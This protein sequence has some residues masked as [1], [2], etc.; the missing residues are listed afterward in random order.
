[1][2]NQRMRRQTFNSNSS[3]LINTQP[4]KKIPRVIPNAPTTVEKNKLKPFTGIA[5][6]EM[7]QNTDDTAEPLESCNGLFE[8]D[9][10]SLDLLVQP[11]ET[12]DAQKSVLCKALTSLM[13]D[14]GTSDED[15]EEKGNE[16]LNKLSE[17]KN[18]KPDEPQISN[19]NKKDIPVGD[20]PKIVDNNISEDEGPEEVVILKT[21]VEHETAPEAVTKTRE[22]PVKKTVPPRIPER[23]NNKF[24]RKIPST[25]LQKLLHQEI[26]KERNIVLQCIRYIKKCNYFEEPIQ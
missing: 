11:K 21:N 14:Y 6:I 23:L 17:T 25:L 3:V 20:K 15:T 8:D 13:C 5:N 7:D 4:A 19:K 9:E 1:M 18:Q 24:K 12:T 26:R 16:A 2:Q 22:K 10:E